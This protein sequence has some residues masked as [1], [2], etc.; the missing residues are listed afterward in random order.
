MVTTNPGDEDPV[1]PSEI[2]C[3]RVYEVEPAPMTQGDHDKELDL[4]RGKYGKFFKCPDQFDHF[5][6]LP[7]R[8]EDR[9][10]FLNR[11]L[12]LQHEQF[13]SK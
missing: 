12:E 6:M 7:L 10:L 3:P 5:C 4:M 13:A 11:C 1:D 8:P 2:T 9:M